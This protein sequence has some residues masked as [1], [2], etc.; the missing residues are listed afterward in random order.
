MFDFTEIVKMSPSVTA[1]KKRKANELDTG[2]PVIE[3][4]S[5]KARKGDTGRKYK[6]VQ[7]PTLP[8]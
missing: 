4:P 2:K 3:E 6:G 7:K 5:L 1:S 8:F